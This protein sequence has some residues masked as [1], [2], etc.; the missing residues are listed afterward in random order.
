ME[1]RVLVLLR[2]LFLELSFKNQRSK[3]VSTF[4]GPRII[5]LFVVTQTA[6]VSVRL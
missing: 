2:H 5:L 6:D 4:Y 3:G 1:H